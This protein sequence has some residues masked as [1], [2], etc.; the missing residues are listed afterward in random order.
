VIETAFALAQWLMVAPLTVLAFPN[1]RGE[2]AKSNSRVEEVAPP[3][4]RCAMMLMPGPCAMNPLWL[5]LEQGNIRCRTSAIRYKST[6][7]GPF[8]G[9]SA[10]CYLTVSCDNAAESTIKEEKPSSER[11]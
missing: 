9:R 5:R 3:I 10:K 11:M 4:M 6:A 2:T 1:R 7:N 8:D